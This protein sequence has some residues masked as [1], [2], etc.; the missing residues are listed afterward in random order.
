MFDWSIIRAGR[1]HSSP[2]FWNSNIPFGVTFLPHRLRRAPHSPP[3]LP[4]LATPGF[5]CS[6]VIS[7][8]DNS[9][10]CAAVFFGFFLRPVPAASAAWF[11]VGGTGGIDTQSFRHS[12]SSS[13]GRIRIW[14]SIF[15][16]HPCQLG[17]ANV[18][19]R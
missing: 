14:P 18:G 16:S 13:A 4:W 15:A 1:G 19:T 7:L 17:L 8:W 10:Q 12:P 5:I 3:P 2:H 11:Q 9:A 6:A